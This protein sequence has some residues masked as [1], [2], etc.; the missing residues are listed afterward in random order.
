M[1]TS[2]RVLE[3]LGEPWGRPGCA[4][5][6][7]GGIL[8]GHGVVLKAYKR[9]LGGSLGRLGAV[10]GALGAMLEPS[11]GQKAQ[12]IEPKRVP[13]RAPEATRAENGETLICNESTKHFDVFSILRA[14][15]FVI[16]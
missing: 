7:L 13:G 2:W 8:G 4:G 6:G 10:L 11:G 15:F 5:G 3:D 1:E 9:H 12:Q 16:K 14:S